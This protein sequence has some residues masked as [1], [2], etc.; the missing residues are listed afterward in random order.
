MI[1]VEDF[2]FNFLDKLVVFI[3]LKILQKLKKAFDESVGIAWQGGKI[4]NLDVNRLAC[5]YHFGQAVPK[6]IHV[7]AV[8][9]G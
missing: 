1:I 6:G 9:V 3:M 5:V 2:N 4:F 7:G 8:V